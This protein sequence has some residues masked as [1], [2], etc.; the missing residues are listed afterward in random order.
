MR[1]KQLE[2]M[3]DSRDPFKHH[4]LCYE[5]GH[6]CHDFGVVLH[7]PA[8]KICKSV[9]V[10]HFFHRLQMFDSSTTALF[11]RSME[12]LCMD[13]RYPEKSLWTK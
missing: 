10:L 1:F 8:V 2:C 9:E 7:E 3:V 4:V 12:T 5:I 11:L 6:V 13:M